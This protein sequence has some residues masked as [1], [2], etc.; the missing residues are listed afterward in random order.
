MQHGE[1]DGDAKEMHIC[2]RAT[3]ACQGAHGGAYS[4]AKANTTWT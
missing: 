1:E 2:R 4:F 3:I